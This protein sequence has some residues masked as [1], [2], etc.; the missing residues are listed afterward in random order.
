MAAPG[1]VDVMKWLIH[2]AME[3]AR[4]EARARLLPLAA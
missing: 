4:P 1:G 2:R 3:I